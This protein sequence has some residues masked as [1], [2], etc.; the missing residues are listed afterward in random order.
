LITNS[1]FPFVNKKTTEK[2]EDKNIGENEKKISFPFVNK[3]ITQRK[4]E[5]NL[6]GN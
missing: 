3:R 4:E 2:K 1:S 6:Y 5:M